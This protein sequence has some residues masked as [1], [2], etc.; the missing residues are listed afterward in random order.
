MLPLQ[1]A[2]VAVT[3]EARESLG[4][5]GVPLPSFPFRVGRRNGNASGGHSASAENP[6]DLY[7]TDNG[8]RSFHISNEHFAIEFDGARFFLTDRQSACG[9]IVAGRRI[10]GNRHGGRTELQP[11][12][13][14][15]VGT[16]HSRYIFRFEVL[17]DGD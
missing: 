13:E 11:G 9:T 3:P 1:A 15:V 7:L 2:L 8:E 17:S 10:G 4:A 5:D 6:N 16:S 12:D 14:I